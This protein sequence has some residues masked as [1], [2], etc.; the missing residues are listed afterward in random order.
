MRIP[1]GCCKLL[2]VLFSVLQ[3][4]HFLLCTFLEQSR[5]R[6]QCYGSLCVLEK[7]LIHSY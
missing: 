1:H 3:V 6:E 4:L 5:N 2:W 7:H